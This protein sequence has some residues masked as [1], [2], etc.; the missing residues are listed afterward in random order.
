MKHFR[1][2]EK[3]SNENDKKSLTWLECI[4]VV[5]SLATAL[6]SHSTYRSADWIFLF[7]PHEERHFN[8]NETWL[9]RAN[10]IK[11]WIG[12]EIIKLL[13]VVINFWN[14][15][16]SVTHVVHSEMKR[17][18]ARRSKK[19]F[20]MLL[21]KSDNVW[22]TIRFVYFT[23][24][25]VK[26][27]WTIN[28]EKWIRFHFDRTEKSDFNENFIIYSSLINLQFWKSKWKS[29]KRKKKTNKKPLNV[30]PETTTQGHNTTQQ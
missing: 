25:T 27:E 19:V 3:N 26:V 7:I 14:Y 2:N 24:T 10:W 29:T 23:A 9:C 22:L 15:D 1:A 28:K 11:K 18:R 12:I 30:S 16:K 21:K 17:E 6:H 13:S 8:I 4:Y 5:K 20:K